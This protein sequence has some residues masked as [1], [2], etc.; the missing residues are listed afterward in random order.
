MLK[1]ACRQRGFQ[2]DMDFFSIDMEK[3]MESAVSSEFPNAEIKYCSFHVGQ[4]WKKQM[5]ETYKLK[6]LYMNKKSV[7]GRLLRKLHGLKS[8]DE[9]MVAPCFYAVFLN[10]KT[11]KRL[12]P[13]FQYIERNYIKENCSFPIKRWANLISMDIE[14]SKMARNHSMLCLGDVFTKPI[15]MCIWEKC[16]KWKEE[17]RGKVALSIPG[18]IDQRSIPNCWIHWERKAFL[19]QRSCLLHHLQWL[20]WPNPAVNHLSFDHANEC[21]QF[22]INHIYAYGGKIFVV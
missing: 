21:A 8:L 15:Q 18:K 12:V 17:Q 19:T 5:F 11:P 4:A 9:D 22:C 14:S 16:T 20:D 10:D 7:S 6:T 2:I 3:A 13:F 1:V